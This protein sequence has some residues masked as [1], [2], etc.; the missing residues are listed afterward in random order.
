MAHTYVQTDPYIQSRTPV[1]DSWL[2]TIFIWLKVITY[3]PHVY[4]EEMNAM[5]QPPYNNGLRSYCMTAT[6]NLDH[7]PFDTEA[8]NELAW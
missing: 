3:N 5:L 4:T 7:I 6:H 8:S 2:V 1:F